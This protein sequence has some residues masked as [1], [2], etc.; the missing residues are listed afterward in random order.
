MTNS[1]ADSLNQRRQSLTKQFLDNL[2]ELLESFWSKDGGCRK[3]CTA[4]MLGML[5]K[6]M[7]SFG[8]EVPR[9]MGQPAEEKSFLQLQEFSTN[10]ET[11]KWR[12]PDHGR[13]HECSF[14]GKT[15][16]WLEKMS[17]VD[18]CHGVRYGDFKL[19]SSV[20]KMFTSSVKKEKTKEQA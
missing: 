20:Q 7:R 19:A 1:V 8:L 14:R 5:I 17:A 2:Y 11:P 13:S 12:D 9:A 16:P 4:I 10:L 15:D 6:Q 3:E 18:I